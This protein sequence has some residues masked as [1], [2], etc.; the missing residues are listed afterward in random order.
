MQ[1]RH[2]R[3]PAT[4]DLR[5]APSYPGGITPAEYAR[6][7]NAAIV[8]LA[9]AAALMATAAAAALVILSIAA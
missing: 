1:N 2:N 3:H 8:F 4:I 5:N 7:I 9:K 6:R